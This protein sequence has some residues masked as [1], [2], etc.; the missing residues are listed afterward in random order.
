MMSY[1]GHA[2]ICI[3]RPMIFVS[4]GR[5]ADGILRERIRETRALDGLRGETCES[6][7]SARRDGC[8]INLVSRSPDN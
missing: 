3:E 5:S 8:M 2:A 6:Q 4:A 1:N 7:L